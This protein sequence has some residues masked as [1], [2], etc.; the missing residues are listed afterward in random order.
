MHTVE[1]LEEALQLA[2]NQGYQVRQE[3]L[4]G[5]RGGS[6]EI[7]GTK[8]IFLNLADSPWEQLQ[9]V[10]SE[11]ATTQACEDVMLSSHLRSL[12]RQAAYRNRRFAKFYT[13]T[14]WSDNASVPRCKPRPHVVFE[15]EC[16][17]DRRRGGES[18]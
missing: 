7:K 1:L 12:L 4:A 2:K 9:Q 6:C 10:C 14:Q 13:S 5:N 11:L 16:F 17:S 15:S 3:W 18:R 8:W